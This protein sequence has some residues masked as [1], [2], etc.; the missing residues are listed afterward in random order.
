ME[1]HSDMMG[2][3]TILY[4]RCIFYMGLMARYVFM[5]IMLSIQVLFHTRQKIIYT[6]VNYKS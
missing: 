6:F 1:S 3:E 4:W 5:H 2:T